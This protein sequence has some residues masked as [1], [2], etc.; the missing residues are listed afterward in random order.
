MA[1]HV[2]VGVPTTPA[3]NFALNVS[4]TFAGPAG[5]IGLWNPD[6]PGGGDNL[7]GIAP[8]QFVTTATT[9]S[10]GMQR[11]Q[12]VQG[13]TAGYPYATGIIEV[14]AVKK[15]RTQMYQASV[16]ANTTAVTFVWAAATNT[17]SFKIVKTSMYTD[18]AE[19]TNPTGSYDDR[20]DQI[21]NYTFSHGANL[22]AMC[23]NA[24]AVINADLGA[25][26]TAVAT[27]TTVTITAKDNGTGFQIIDTSLLID[28]TNGVAMATWGALLSGSFGFTAGCG[29]GWQAVAAERKQ[30]HHRSA[31]HNRIGFPV[32]QPELFATLAG[33]YD[34][35]TII[36]QH[37][38]TK[39][40]MKDSTNNR[41][42]YSI[43]IYVPSGWTNASAGVID[44]HFTA[45]SSASAAG[46]V[47]D[48]YTNPY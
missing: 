33:T 36:C 43:D 18:D 30:Q 1:K 24:A 38:G 34:V 10:P 26:V 46:T 9:M 17:G 37:Q 11:F 13:T 27:A 6:L 20:V 25:F 3:A 31:F 41:D 21:R 4:T 12:V 19:F 28:P 2:F 40:A 47:I 22:A 5:L 14:G 23:A 15:I 44:S 42:Q 16:V 35:V 8:E 45:L 48:I 39:A 7:N 32:Q 29:N